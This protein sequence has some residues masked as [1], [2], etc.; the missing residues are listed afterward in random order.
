M[1]KGIIRPLAICIFQKGE[2]I[3]VSEGTDP[4]TGNYF[5]RPVGGGIEYGERSSDAVIREVKE[6]IGADIC[7]LKLLGTLEN[8]FT[9]DGDLGHEIVQVYAADFIDSSYYNL[10]IFKGKE[11]NGIEFDVMW[12]PLSDFQKESRLVP[13]GLFELL[14]SKV[15]K[16]SS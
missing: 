16:F 6:E 12:K 1:R 14:K 11:D 5:Y 3:L 9:Y 2:S 8:I 15:S 4:K 7:H 13:E 10:S